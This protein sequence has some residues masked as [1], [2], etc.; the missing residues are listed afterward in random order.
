[1]Y[2]KLKEPAARY[3]S[4]SPPRIRTA[5][6]LPAKKIEKIQP[7]SP[8][9][10]DADDVIEVYGPFDV[11]D[12]KQPK[13]LMRRPGAP[14][15]CKQTISFNQPATQLHHDNMYPLFAPRN[16]HVGSS[17][18][19]NRPS[20]SLSPPT[21][22]GVTK[23]NPV[24]TTARQKKATSQEAE[25]PPPDQEETTLELF[26]YRTYNPDPARVYVTNVDEANDLVPALRGPI[27]F[28]MEWRV[29]YARPKGAIRAQV[30]SNRTATIQVC[31][32]RMI[33][34]IQI[35]GMQ[36]FP[37][38]LK[39]LIESKTIVKMGANILND[40]VKLFGDYGVVAHNLVE[41]GALARQAD[42]G[43]DA[44][45]VTKA[46]KVRHS[47]LGVASLAKVIARYCGKTLEKPKERTSDWEVQPLTE[48]QLEYAAND[49]YSALKAYVRILEIAKEHERELT[50][51]GY[52]RHVDS[53]VT[54][55][56]SED[57]LEEEEEGIDDLS[58]AE[59][60]TASSTQQT[61]TISPSAIIPLSHPGMRPQ[62][63]RAYRLWHIKG[64]DIDDLCKTL[65]TVGP[66]T[67]LK[68][69]TVIAYVI[70]ALQADVKLAFDMKKLW[71]L[72]QMEASSWSHHKAWLMEAGKAGRGTSNSAS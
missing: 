44:L 3:Y 25:S 13:P 5:S 36:R 52:T 1:M 17:I 37:Q 58:T 64:M 49:A 65:S 55:L 28:D 71:K 22:G 38:A 47:S 32:Q 31:D 48:R 53:S 68:R 39:E 10:E 21:V 2:P 50:P 67:P 66:Q 24:K 42:P 54:G 4:T 34:V 62:Q 72:V 8:C 35:S 27:G 6:S 40:G 33:L 45:F 60:E 9:L 11:Q 41:L 69:S 59:V 29:R 15:K 51:S 43:A 23:A 61:T 57:E 12:I 18:S 30:I 14:S 16:M 56:A 7:R 20:S 63:W 46:G 19:I 70:G 26:S